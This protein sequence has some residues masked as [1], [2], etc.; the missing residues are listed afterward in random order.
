[1]Q[2]HQAG[3]LSY[4][5]PVVVIAVVLALRFRRM[6]RERRLRLGALWVVPVLYGAVAA[7]MFWQ[8]PPHGL[9]WAWV[10]L[11]FAI[12]AGLGWQRGRLM[13]IR[14]DPETGTLNQK[15][16]PA[17]MIFIVALI[18]VRQVLRI[19]MTGAGAQAWHVSAALVTDLF[20]AFALGLFALQRLEMFLRARRL[21]AEA[22]A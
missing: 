19:A 2:A 11:G 5:I 15:G 12:G 22:Q 17:A 6:S 20:V 10:A 13:E 4:V 8:T 18:A 3:W 7:L 21:L 14:V 16:S 1:M 9:Q